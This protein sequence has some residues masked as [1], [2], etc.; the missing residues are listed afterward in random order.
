MPPQN[1]HHLD[2]FSQNAS[3]IDVTHTKRKSVL[4][5]ETLRCFNNEAL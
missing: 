3:D 1:M 4:I 5:Y 2:T